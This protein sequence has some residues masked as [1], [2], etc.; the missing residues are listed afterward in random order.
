MA[1]D[2][3]EAVERAA[4]D[5]YGKLL[6]FLS[7][8]S[9]DIAA[10]EDALADAF[11]AALGDWPRSG[12]PGNPEAWLLTAARGRYPVRGAGGARARS[13]SRGGARGHLRRLWQRLGRRRRGQQLEG[14]LVGRSDLSRP[15]GRGAAPQRAGGARPARAD[16]ALRGAPCR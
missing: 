8:R 10:A 4:R 7:A 12:I 13:P 5:S 15:A 16:A 11:G 2:A 6:A 1:A 9:R 3:H 14:R